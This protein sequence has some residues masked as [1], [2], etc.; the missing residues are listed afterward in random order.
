MSDKSITERMIML[1]QKYKNEYD[2]TSG[3]PVRGIKKQI[4]ARVVND[5][6]DILCSEGN[7]KKL[8]EGDKHD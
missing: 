1:R 8:R 3:A 7:E 2:S 4:L 5:L 6:T